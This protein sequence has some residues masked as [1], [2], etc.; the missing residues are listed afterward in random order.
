LKRG[1]SSSVYR[2]KNGKWDSG[3]VEKNPLGK[4][5]KISVVKRG[6]SGIAREL[7]VKG[8]RGTFLIRKEYNIRKVLGGGIS[9]KGKNGKVISK[10]M[11]MLPSAFFGIESRAGSF[12]IHG[13]GFGHGVGMPQWGA[14]D[15]VQKKGFEYDDILKRYYPNSDFARASKF[16]KNSDSLSVLIGQ[17]GG[18][19][20]KV[21]KLISED[22]M[23]VRTKWGKYKIKKDTELEFGIKNSVIEI[24]SA[25]KILVKTGEEIRIESDKKIGVKSNPKRQMKKGYPEYY[26]EFIIR[27]YKAERMLLINRVDL[28]YYLRGVLP[29]EMPPS[30]GLEALKAQAVSSRTYAVT[31]ILG[32][33]YSRYGVNL[34]DS[35]SS[36]VYN[37]SN[38][39]EI[40]NRAIKETKGKILIYNNKPIDT[41]FYSSSWGVSAVPE[42]I[43]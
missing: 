31:G 36:Q 41:F 11:S 27:P 13:G 2:L 40:A 17:G 32:N 20:Q 37:N 24:K 14:R 43:W 9:V 26:G 28:E 19:E 22:T 30:F 12:K 39:S 1:N 6:A 29:S 35:V 42:E 5:K 25:G 7:L 3:K 21:I 38:E 34:V 15:L 18:F 8:S 4:L 10:N 33:K 23:I 16:V